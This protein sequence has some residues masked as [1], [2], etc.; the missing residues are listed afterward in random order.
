MA[1][2]LETDPNTLTRPYWNV[3][4]S[5]HEADN[6]LFKDE[7]IVISTK[8]RSDML[9]TAHQGH[10]GIKKTKARARKVI[11]WPGISSDIEQLISKC[12][13]C[14]THRNKN[15]RE[16]LLPHSIPERPCWQKVGS[17][18]F[19]YQGKSYLLVIDYSVKVHWNKSHQ[20]QDSI[21][22]CH[23]H[24]INV[25]PAWHSRRTCFW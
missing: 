25:C 18:I 15:T 10:L 13:T 23:P 5:L 4:H 9:K 2:S 16:P 14:N 12:A 1:N 19:E 7:C 6:L 17:D 20:G 11:Y 8:L 24:E 3:R 22:S 21:D